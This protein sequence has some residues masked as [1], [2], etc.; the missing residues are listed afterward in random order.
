M[1][2]KY[3]AQVTEESILLT[4]TDGKNLT[5]DLLPTAKSP[6]KLYSKAR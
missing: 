5:V 4:H 6:K 1:L 2:K 3:N